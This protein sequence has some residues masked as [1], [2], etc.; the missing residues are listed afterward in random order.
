M[1]DQKEILCTASLELLLCCFKERLVVLT[2]EVEN[3]V[4]IYFTTLGKISNQMLIKSRQC[5]CIRSN[6]LMTGDFVSWTIYVKNYIWCTQN[7][8]LFIKVFL[9]DFS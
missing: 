4:T 1:L 7:Q 9:K 8:A 5:M 6:P 3:Y 2:R